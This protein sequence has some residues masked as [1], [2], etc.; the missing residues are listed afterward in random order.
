MDADTIPRSWVD[1]TCLNDNLPRIFLVTALII[2]GGF[3]AGSETAFSFCSPVKIRMLADR[4]GCSAKRVRHILDSFDRA[5]VT[6][7][8]LINIC[9]I[10]A[11]SV[12]TVIAL[13][14]FAGLQ[15]AAASLISTVFTTLSIFIFAETIPKNIA[16]A[17]ADAYAMAVSP[18]VTVF[19]FL[20]RPFAAVLSGVGALVKKLLRIHENEPSVTEDE[21]AVMVEDAGDGGILGEGES[22]IIISAIEFSNTKASDIMTPRSEIA[23]IPVRSEPEDVKKV[24]LSEK[25]SRFPVYRGSINNIVGIL[26]AATALYKLCSG[27]ALDITKVMTKPYAVAPDDSIA[28]VFEGMCVKHT[29]IS[30]V[31]DEHGR[32]LGILSMED[33]LEQIVGEIYDEDDEENGGDDFTEENGGGAE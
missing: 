32:T 31:R 2:T 14:V 25:F 23:G 20:L 28:A 17:N 26:H 30:V 4:G 5:I 8:I 10:T 24:L 18:I 1:F 15:D 3:F 22:D 16:R 13:D 9:Y 11:S 19:M 7:L 21:F 27:E 29:H 12:S 33:I 6:L